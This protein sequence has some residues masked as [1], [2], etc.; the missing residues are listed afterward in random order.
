[1]D[2]KVLIKLTKQHYPRSLL[3]PNSKICIVIGDESFLNVDDTESS[4]QS[5]E[6]L[7]NLKNVIEYVEK[8]NTDTIVISY[9]LEDYKNIESVIGGR[10]GWGLAS[11]LEGGVGYRVHTFGVQQKSQSQTFP[12]G[13]GLK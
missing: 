8:S 2:A 5:S 3:P 13:F 10:I 12:T 1:M 9:A 11:K 7:K 4:S 6:K